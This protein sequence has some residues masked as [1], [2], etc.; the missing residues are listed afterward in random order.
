[1][2][3]AIALIGNAPRTADTFAAC[4]ALDQSARIDN[5]QPRSLRTQ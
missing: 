4:G 5:G 1:M 3:V 2:I